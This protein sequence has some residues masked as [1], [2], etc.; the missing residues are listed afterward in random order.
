[1]TALAT[2]NFNRADAGTL[3]S[4]WTTQA[5]QSNGFAISANTAIP[6]TIGG[7]CHVNYNA[8]TWP[9][10]QYSQC[11]LAALIGTSDQAGIGPSVRCSTTDTS[12][13]RMVACLAI[14]N[15]SALSKFVA[16][17]YTLIAQA[18]AGW[19]VTTDTAYLEMQGTTL[20]GKRNSTQIF[21]TTDSSI[22]S[23]RAGMSYS[24]T[25]TA[26]GNDN[27]EGGDFSGG[28]TRPVKMAS[29]WL[30]YAGSSGGFAG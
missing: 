27:W 21:S 20:K 22:S 4:N 14:T 5:G 30:G 9:N 2:D 3:G 18:T 12:L 6:D 1:M 15:D 28:T 16:G 23:G 11:L 25:M 19:V 10:D 24:S 13:Y 26:A 7:D 8:V 17:S 29:Q